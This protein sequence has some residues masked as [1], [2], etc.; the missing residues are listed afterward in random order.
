M[1]NTFTQIGAALAI[2]A[3]TATGAAA[4]SSPY[5]KYGSEA[6]WDIF[7]NTKTNNCLIARGVEQQTQ[8]QMGIDKTANNPRGYIALYTKKGADVGAGE[9]INVLFDVDGQQFSGE[10]TGAKMEGFDGAYVYVNNIDFIY[11][12]AKKK[13]MTITPQGRP[14]LLVSLSGTDAAFK[15]LRA[16]Q[17]SR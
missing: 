1:M 15:A 12:L 7:V 13:T 8:V 14:P 4:Q 3:L 2:A 17:E 9:K 6:G 5:Q 16:C 10:A 11:D